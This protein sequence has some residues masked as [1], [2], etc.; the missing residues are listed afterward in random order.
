MGGFVGTGAAMART[1][2]PRTKALEGIFVIMQTP[3]HQNLEI[4]EESLRHETDFLCRCGAHGLVWPA[5]AGETNSIW[6]QKR[7]RF[8]DH[9]EG[10]PQPDDRADRRAWRE[11]VRG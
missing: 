3:F 4:D 6:H 2:Q 7:L 8:S 10:S 9:C 11:Q 1:A 5:G